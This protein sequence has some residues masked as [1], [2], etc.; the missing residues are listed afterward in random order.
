MCLFLSFTLAAGR[1]SSCREYAALTDDEDMKSP[2][3]I[4][5]TDK[6]C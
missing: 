3:S 6:S 4:L 1:D 5:I 2:I